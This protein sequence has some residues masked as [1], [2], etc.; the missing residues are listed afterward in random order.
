[1]GPAGRRRVPM[2]SR[3]VQQAGSLPDLTLAVLLV[4]TART[5]DAACAHSSALPGVL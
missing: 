5:T 3:G 1:M 4:E 2:R